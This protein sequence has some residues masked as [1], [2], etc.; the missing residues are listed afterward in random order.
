L[1]LA[2]CLLIFVP[3][4]GVTYTRDSTPGISMLTL[5]GVSCVMF[6]LYE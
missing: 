5:G 2:C 3:L 4:S 6:V 1:N